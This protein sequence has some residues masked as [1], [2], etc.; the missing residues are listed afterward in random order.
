MIDNKPLIIRDEIHGDMAFE[1]VLRQVIDHPTFQRLRYIKQLGLAEYVFP[2]ANHSRFQHSL[3]ASYLAGRYFHQLLRAWTESPFESE[4]QAGET[5]LFPQRT[6]QCVSQVAADGASLRFWRQVVGL[7]G[8]LHD[9]GHGPWSHSFEQLELAQDFRDQAEGLEGVLRDYFR[10]MEKEGA[11]YW[12]EDLSLLYIAHILKPI[13]PEMIFPVACLVNKNLLSPSWKAASEKELVQTFA[14]AKVKGG[15]EFHTLLR[16]IVSG[17]F[18]VDR[19]DY[20]QR[21]GRNCGVSIGGIEWRRIVSKVIPCLADHPSAGDQPRDV[22]LISNSKNQHVLDDFIF[23]LFQMYAQVYLHPKVVGLEEEIKN[24]LKATTPKK[25]NGPVVTFALHHG[26]TDESFR[27]WLASELSATAIDDILLRKQ[28]RKFRA[29]SYPAEDE[30]TSELSKNGYR[31]V[32]IQDRPMMKDSMGI[33]LYSAIRK[34]NGN[35]KSFFVKPWA[36]VSP[37]VKHFE[38]IHYA[39]NIWLKPENGAKVPDGF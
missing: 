14:K 32:D 19:I 35:E 34:G 24:C 20:I 11:R 3:G 31:L 28:G 6:H 9:I 22:C 30:F 26:F 10:V 23:S 27:A 8:L 2:C 1:G 4:F 17:P 36:Q 33:F 12:H 7:G 21:D 16:P 37:I 29:A 25:K 15:V 13:A 39:P 18:D 5:Q 38:S